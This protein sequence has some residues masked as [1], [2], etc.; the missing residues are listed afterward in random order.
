MLHVVKVHDTLLGIAKRYG[1]TV[2]LIMESNVICNPNYI[3]IGQPLIIPEPN[4]LLLKSGGI[5]YY[6][7]NYGDT[8][9]CLAKQFSQS[10]ESLITANKLQNSN[11]LYPGMELLVNYNPPANPEELFETWD[12]TVLNSLTFLQF[13]GI[14]FMNT[15]TWEALGENATPYLAKLL[16]HEN[17]QV[18]YY[19]V[20][21][22][23]RIGTGKGTFKALQRALKDNDNL[24]VAT[25]KLAL[26]RYQL[27]SRWTKRIHIVTEE[28]KLL[29]KPS[30]S[31]SSIPITSGTPIIVLTWRIPDPVDEGWSTVNYNPPIYDL[32]KI[33]ET[34]QTGYLPRG[35]HYE[36]INF[37]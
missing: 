35:S 10:I 20:L 5:P 9:L 26:K 34:G 31:A 16:N 19:T 4:L 12:K 36:V 15:F 11:Q 6:V 23:G 32:I 17:S 3:Y 1:T 21:S 24:V 29:N 28:T 2:E 13:I 7:V 37:I 27:I 22:L 14:Y 33:V 18:R 8:L 25:A 30:L